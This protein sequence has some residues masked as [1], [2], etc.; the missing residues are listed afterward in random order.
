VPPVDW[1][2]PQEIDRISQAFPASV[3]GKLLPLEKD[4]PAPYWENNHPMAEVV[5]HWFYFGLNPK[6]ELE[7]KAGVDGHVMMQHLT[8]CLRSF[9]PK[10]QHKIA[11]VAFLLDQW[12]SSITNWK[13]EKAVDEMRQKYVLGRLPA[14]NPNSPDHKPVPITHGNTH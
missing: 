5:S 13:N 8:T 9:E 3:I 7:L 4:I 12:I 14:N 2:K 11:G 6:A 1:S 10:H